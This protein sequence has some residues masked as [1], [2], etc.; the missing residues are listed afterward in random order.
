MRIINIAFIIISAVIFT[1]CQK[2]INETDPVTQASNK[3]KTYT[4]DVT[5]LSGH[6][7]ITLNVAYDASD[8]IVS[9]TSAASAGD[10]FVFL[11]SNGGYTMDLYNSNQ[12][13]IHEIFYLNSNS[14]VDSSFQYNDTNDSMTEGYYYDAS[15]R[16]VE[17]REYEYSTATGAVY[18]GSTQFAY[19]SIGDLVTETAIS[20]LG[21]VSSISTYTSSAYATPAGF[22]RGSNPVYNPLGAHLPASV[23]VTY[24][25]SPIPSYSGSYAYTFDSANRLTSQIFTATTG[26]TGKAEFIY[27]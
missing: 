27:Y 26:E 5:S 9:L 8:R 2:G 11:Y 16:L 20:Y 25:P 1:S 14:L 3:V 24:P 12:L 4:E 17:K 18:D 13:S 15:N 23:S 6:N 19:S 22:L 10:R 7:V 21:N